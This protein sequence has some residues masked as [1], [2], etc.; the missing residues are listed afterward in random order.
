MQALTVWLILVAFI[1]VMAKAALGHIDELDRRAGIKR[2]K[3]VT[4]SVRLYRAIKRKI[5][6]KE[7]GADR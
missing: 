5:S 1:V 2:K 4:L 3:H 6:G 7:E